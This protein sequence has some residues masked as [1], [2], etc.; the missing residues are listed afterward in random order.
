MQDPNAHIQQL[1]GQLPDSAQRVLDTAAAWRQQD[2]YDYA[3]E[4][5]RR[6]VERHPITSFRVELARTFAE[7]GKYREAMSSLVN[8]LKLDPNHVDALL[9][10]AVSMAHCG[11]GDRSHKMLDRAARAGA[12]ADVVESIRRE[13]VGDPTMERSYQP[14]APPQ[15]S[16]KQLL[17]DH[18]TPASSQPPHRNEQS[19]PQR[20][21]AIG[22][23]LSD[24]DDS[25]PPA[26]SVPRIQTGEFLDLDRYESADANEQSLI[27]SVP[28]VGSDQQFD[29][30]LNDMGVPVESQPAMKFGAEPETVPYQGEVAG[31]DD[32][33]TA[34]N[35]SDDDLPTGHANASDSDETQ[36]IVFED[37]V[38]EPVTPADPATDVA[39]WQQAEIGSFS[40]GVDIS[41]DQNPRAVEPQ[42][43]Q[44]QAQPRY[45]SSE[46]PMVSNANR[47]PTPRPDTLDS[48]ESYSPAAHQDGFFDEG[49]F[50]TD[51]APGDQAQNQQTDQQAPQ[52]MPRSEQQPQPH[53]QP[54]P[55]Q[56]PGEQQLPNGGEFSP[57]S[58]V[59]GASDDGS[60]GMDLRILMAVAFAGIL[61]VVAVGAVAVSGI[62]ETRGVKAHIETAE[63]Q[64]KP[65]TFQA[66]QRT[67][68]ALE[69]AVDH[70]GF[71]NITL[72]GS[73]AP[74]LKS[75]AA[76]KFLFTLA[77][78]DYRFGGVEDARIEKARGVAPAQDPTAIAGNAMLALSENDPHRADEIAS[79]ARDAFPGNQHVETAQ[80]YAA[81]EL[82]QIE[83]ARTAAKS[84]RSLES[85]S[86]HISY[87]L[88]LVDAR[89]E[90]A[91]ALTGLRK[92]L[93]AHP[94]HV[95]AQIQLS[96]LLRKGEDELVDAKK[97]L[98]KIV[99]RR[100]IGPM[101]QVR[102]RSALARAHESLG[103]ESKAEVMLRDA[104]ELEPGRAL[105]YEELLDF[106]LDK[107]RM[108]EVEKY[109]AKAEEADARSPRVSFLE[110]ESLV[111]TSR[112]DKAVQA[113]G[114]LKFEDVR[115]EWWRG[116]GY[117]GLGRDQDALAAFKSGAKLAGEF[118]PVL[119]FKATFEARVENEKR[120]DAA[121]ALKNA[122]ETRAEDPEV[123]YASALFEIDR[124]RDTESSSTRRKRLD[125]AQEY[126]EKALNLEK[127]ERFY[128]S[129]CAAHVME[130]DGEDAEKA[131]ENGRDLNDA[132]VPGLLALA[133]LRRLQGR[134]N[135][136]IDIL[137]PLTKDRP[138]DHQV[139]IL[140]A[141][142]VLENRQPGRA[143]EIVDGWLGKGVAER[144]FGLLEG[145]IQ[146]ERRNF[147]RAA[148][149]LKSA[150]EA[151]KTDG[152][153]AVFYGATL[154]ALGQG[155]EA[156]PLLRDTISH[157]TWG[158]HAWMELGKLRHDQ[159]RWKD[160]VENFAGAR[161]EFRDQ[162]GPK[163]RFSELYASWALAYKDRWSWSDRR[164][165]S[166]LDDG[167][168]D[169]DPDDPDLNKAWAL[170]HMNQRRP[171][172]D[173]AKKYLEKAIEAAPYRCDVYKLLRPMVE[174]KD[175]RKQLDE[176]VRE[177]NCGNDK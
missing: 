95:D 158:G 6:C 17:P 77:M 45:V 85:P 41:N 93:E 177:H 137:E 99:A 56:Q 173:A 1:L 94:D 101:Q 159:K 88:N 104:L 107:R 134:Y 128:F 92:F 162:T 2:E 47:E 118:H 175:E 22:A 72:P 64:I 87:V 126:L 34:L 152:E 29:Q 37:E 167:R 138:D 133:D 105:A 78:M 9:I 82:Q 97:R 149:Y 84:L 71:L 67:A 3:L 114:Q 155:D 33:T 121:F 65:D 19:R 13:V 145:R 62:S 111:R 123:F 113:M 70:Q 150:H 80:I 124:A 86:T 139:S 46:P 127:D 146:Y 12:R 24:D 23:P 42:Q 142:T 108:D 81:L 168:D 147:T 20:Q 16:P 131:C 96:R 18:A 76:A 51:L 172:R 49:Q 63:T 38:F 143:Q 135:E 144:E 31:P 36:A 102:A 15:T 53:Q 98:E 156:D 115:R 91:G 21:T 73:S 166:K 136:A 50:E 7:I 55:R 130:R 110:A 32:A 35:I 153:A 120:Q 5:L 116:L 8:V 176:K 100:D 165:Y 160:V 83:S 122:R 132:Y 26:P 163:S 90:R 75:E 40:L 68:D 174:E 119:A 117:V 43:N 154:I 48:F 79:A 60:G 10:M 52:R 61:L 161:S 44:R 140:L 141:R 30:L 148:G 103:D 157:P 129:L 109:V 151:D 164:V 169:G 14:A 59:P 57:T 125:S 112:P 74:K 25:I 4:L 27:Q 89:A 69:K 58:A 28:E 171:D 54:R 106:Y 66:Y 11:E 39:G 170:Y